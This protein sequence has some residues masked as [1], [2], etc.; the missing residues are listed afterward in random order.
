MKVPVK[1]ER[2]L[3][4]DMVTNAILANDNMALQNYKQKREK[5]RNKDKKIESLENDINILKENFET[6]VQ[7]INGRIT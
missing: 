1:D 6:L 4:R 7:Q 2:G 3:E 5:L